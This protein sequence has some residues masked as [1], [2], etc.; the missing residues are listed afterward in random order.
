MILHIEPEKLLVFYPQ[1]IALET[2]TFIEYAQAARAY[3][4]SIIIVAPASISEIPIEL[5]H[6]M[7][8]SNFK[9]VNSE[10]TRGHWRLD[11]K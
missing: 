6:F 5:R 4:K 10:L 3:V 9:R 11:L 1:D 2:K 7:K 8:R